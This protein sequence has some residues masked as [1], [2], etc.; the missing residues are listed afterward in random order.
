VV[1][2]FR[3]R[4]SHLDEDTVEQLKGIVALYSYDYVIPDLDTNEENLDEV[5]SSELQL[6]LYRYSLTYH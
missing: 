3:W 5:L 2:L 6:R 1:H 4:K